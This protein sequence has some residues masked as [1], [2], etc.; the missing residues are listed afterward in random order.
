MR[1]RTACAPP[2]APTTT[3]WCA[4]KVVYDPE[5]S[6]AD[7][8]EPPARDLSRARVSGVATFREQQVRFAFDQDVARVN[9][10][11]RE[12]QL[13]V[14][15]GVPLDEWVAAE[16][17]P[18]LVGARRRPARRAD[19][20]DGRRRRRGGPG[21]RALPPGASVRPEDDPVGV[22]R[23]GARGGSG[24]D[25]GGLRAEH[26]RGGRGGRCARRGRAGGHDRSACRCGRG[27]CCT[28]CSTRW[29]TSGTSRSRWAA[30]RR[31]SPSSCRWWPTCC[32]SRRGWPARSTASSP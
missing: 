20:R 8:P 22:A 17:V 1:A 15:G 4:V 30:R 29:S 6:P 10:V 27:W 25:A 26:R 14:V 21:R 18:G 32:W 19:E 3:A 12:R 28:P 9:R 5:N 7:Q 16:P 11:V 23:G 13:E 31:P 24:G 2:T